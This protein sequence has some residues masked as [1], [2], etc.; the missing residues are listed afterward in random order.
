MGVL[1]GY[2]TYILAGITVLGAVASY[3]VGDLSLADGLQLIVTAL[4]GAFIRN[5]VKTDT[6][7]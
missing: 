7:K 1:S 6:N 4:T 3:L 2:K 5:G